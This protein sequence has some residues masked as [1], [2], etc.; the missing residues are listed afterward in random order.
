MQNH[1]KECHPDN[2]FFA[3]HVVLRSR[4]FKLSQIKSYNMVFV[5]NGKCEIE[6]WFYGRWRSLDRF[7]HKKTT[8]YVQWKFHRKINSMTNHF[9]KASR[10]RLEM[11]S[12]FKLKNITEMKKGKRRQMFSTLSSTR[13]WN[14]PNIEKFMI[15]CFV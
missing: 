13:K 11:H 14:E 10:Y 2:V 12:E 15:Y 5:V 3:S 9:I 8:L 6:G 1:L 7:S 4:L